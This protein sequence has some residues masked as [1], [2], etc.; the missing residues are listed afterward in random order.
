MMKW[1]GWVNAA[2]DDWPAKTSPMAA[3]CSKAGPYW[4]A[5]HGHTF[6][7]LLAAI[8]ARTR[9]AGRQRHSGRGILGDSHIP[10]AGQFPVLRDAASTLSCAATGP[11]LNKTH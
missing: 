5:A 3:N 9:F 11:W 2:T 6:S 1:E 8:P 4:E 10:C 7:R